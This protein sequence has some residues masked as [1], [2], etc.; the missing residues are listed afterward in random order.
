MGVIRRLRTLL[1]GYRC[2]LCGRK[3]L[4]WF[5]YWVEIGRFSCVCR[6]CIRNNLVRSLRNQ[7][8]EGLLGTY[9][10]CP[11]CDESTFWKIEREPQG[12]GYRVGARCTRCGYSVIFTKRRYWYSA[13]TPEQES[14]VGVFE[15]RAR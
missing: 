10:Y 6:E 9:H 8:Y 14:G 11:S 13:P 4:K 3:T 1:S 5:N 12:K 7:W 2:K 15:V